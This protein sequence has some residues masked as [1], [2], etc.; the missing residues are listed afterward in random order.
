[1][2]YGPAVNYTGPSTANDL[3]HAWPHI[4]IQTFRVFAP[5]TPEHVLNNLSEYG[6]SIGFIGA[7][8][9]IV[10]LLLPTSIWITECCCH[11]DCCEKLRDSC[12]CDCCPRRCCSPLTFNP[13]KPQADV[14]GPVVSFGTV[15]L[16]LLILTMVFQIKA[17]NNVRDVT[18]ILDQLSDMQTK[19]TNDFNAATDQ[20]GVNSNGLIRLIDNSTTAG[21]TSVQISNL[22]IALIET[23]LASDALGAASDNANKGF[24]ITSNTDYARMVARS[25]VI[26]AIVAFL[27]VLGMVIGGLVAAFQPA[28]PVYQ[29][30]VTFS[31]FLAAFVLIF[32]FLVSVL[33]AGLVAAG[34]ICQ[35]P[36]GYMNEQ[37]Y[38]TG[39]SDYAGYYINCAPGAVFPDLTKLDQ[40]LGY[41][42]DA[43]VR[44]EQFSLYAYENGTFPDLLARSVVIEGGLTLSN[45]QITELIDDSNCTHPHNLLTQALEQGC[46]STFTYNAVWIFA[47]PSAL[48]CL[49][50]LYRALPRAKDQYAY[51]TLNVRRKQQQQSQPP[52]PPPATEPASE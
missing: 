14:L 2:S 13:R 31:S 18:N 28:T 29:A 35:D 48:I 40:A 15:G 27:L 30:I 20:M 11:C 26:A 36:L 47:L 39:N 50:A 33:S 49:L 3:F 4:N 41:S 1:M 7:L 10:W 34:D 51:A 22:Q 8:L 17:A 42:T 32:G 16:V 6:Y 52:S 9:V 38:R 23:Q 45:A 21:V 25:I 19:T 5:I 43:L 46:G 44:V 24:D 12:N 37:N